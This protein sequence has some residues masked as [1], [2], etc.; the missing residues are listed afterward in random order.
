MIKWKQHRCLTV[1]YYL[2]RLLSIHTMEWP[3]AI[4]IIFEVYLV[5]EKNLREEQK[6]NKYLL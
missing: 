3:V 6:L 1:Q 2:N 4:S 5:N